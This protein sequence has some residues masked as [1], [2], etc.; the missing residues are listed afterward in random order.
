MCPIYEYVCTKCNHELEAIQKFTDEPLVKCP[1]C[2]KKSLEKQMS[3]GG[4][5]IL[6]G[7]GFYNRSIE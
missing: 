4:M 7:E 1:K 3:T 5:F 2:K 6:K